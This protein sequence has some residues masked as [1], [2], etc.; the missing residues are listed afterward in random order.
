GLRLMFRNQTGFHEHV[1]IIGNDNF[2]Q[3]VVDLEKEEG[4]KLDTFEYGKKKTPLVIPTIQVVTDQIAG[5]DIAIPTLT[6]RIE[7]KKGAKRIIEELDLANVKLK[8][9]LKVNA[10]EPPTTFTYKG[11]DVITDDVVIER[12]YTMPQAK[13]SSEVVAFYA[14]IIAQSLKLPAQFATL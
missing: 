1:D 14:Q 11:Y 2:M 6:P 9:P 10:V 3:V 12:E 5:Y 4:I 13:T 8:N 7:R